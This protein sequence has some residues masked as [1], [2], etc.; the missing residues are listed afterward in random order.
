VTDDVVEV[1]GEA[2]PVRVGDAWPGALRVWVFRR[3]QPPVHADPARLAELGARE[4]LFVWVDL[5]EYVVE[6]LQTVAATLGLHSIGV[7]ATI[8]AWQRP[9]LD[10]F[11]PQ[12][13]VAATVPHL[14][15]QS[16]KVQVAQLN[17]FVGPNF[18]VSAHKQPL[19]FAKQLETRACQS[20]DLPRLD[21]AF[22]LYLV[23]DELLT[24]Y[25][26]LSEHV[27]DEMEV[28]EERALRVSSETF[29]EEL[30]SAKRYI[31]AL[32]RAAEQHQGVLAAFLRPDFPYVSGEE[33]E[34]YFRDLEAHLIRLLDR[35]LPAKEIINGAFDIYV[36]HMAHR[37][38]NIMKLLTILSTV[39]LPV[40]V[41]LGL[42]GT[43]FQ[44]VPLYG[45][46]QF[47]VMLGSIMLVVVVTL[48]A[49]RWRGWL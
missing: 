9:R 29:L 6:E 31:F 28:M 8:G 24:Y 49:F 14:R 4:D 45:A 2:L 43:N 20:P 35:L 46:S 36:S 26:T 39:V 19:P 23:L 3:G 25:G 12:F 44:D 48:G 7:R 1:E 32:S 16:R 34:P 18:L 30:L 40:S 15:P 22:M 42:F 41:I 47:Y 21:A 11:T 5:S 37:T 33:V 13:Y 17:L 38:N 10:V 27:G